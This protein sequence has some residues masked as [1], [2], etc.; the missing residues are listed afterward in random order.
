VHKLSTWL[1]IALAFVA[2]VAVFTVGFHPAMG[3]AL[4]H[5]PAVLAVL[6]LMRAAVLV[7]QDRSFA[8]QWRG[9]SVL[10]GK[11]GLWLPA[12]F[13]VGWT[14]LRETGALDANCSISHNDFRNGSVSLAWRDGAGEALLPAGIAVKAP[15]NAFGAGVDAALPDHW[16][17]Q[18]HRLAAT[19][20]VDGDA[21]FRPWPLW[22]SASLAY[23]VTVVLQLQPQR[24]S[25][26]VRT[27]SIAIDVEGTWTS[28]GFSSQRK[29]HQWMGGSVGELVRKTI[30]K[31]VDKAFAK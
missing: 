18:E 8:L 15:A 16:L 22:K 9:R 27:S 11:L 2:V 23:R 30:G 6:L 3:L 13:V 25:G 31:H 1:L 7:M 10:G 19:V 28:L 29:Y 17:L 5:V 24:G 21:P 4:L 26:A 12:L 20:S 14:F